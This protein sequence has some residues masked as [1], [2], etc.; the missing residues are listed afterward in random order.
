MEFETF[1]C[2]Q[3]RSGNRRVNL[4]QWSL[5]QNAG[6]VANRLHLCKFTPMEFETFKLSV[7]RIDGFGVNLLQWSLKQQKIVVR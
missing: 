7:D 5:K 4:L 3:D 2:S 6:I 1:R